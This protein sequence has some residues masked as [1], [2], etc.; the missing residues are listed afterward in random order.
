M[1][2]AT[3]EAQ[4]GAYD[5]MVRD[6]RTA[7]ELHLLRGEDAAAGLLF[8]AA[9]RLLNSIGQW[10]NIVPLV[11]EDPDEPEVAAIVEIKPRHRHDFVESTAKGEDPPRCACGH[12]KNPNGRP[13]NQQVIA[14]A[15]KGP[16]FP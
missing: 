5:K 11:I 7:A 9:A 2:K 4:R 12:V 3:Y 15:T 13:R 6:L 10:S 14:P 8:V 16:V 1:M